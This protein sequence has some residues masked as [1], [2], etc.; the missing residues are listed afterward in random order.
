ML[1]ER[2][3]FNYNVANT[4]TS[5]SQKKN[6]I[7]SAIKTNTFGLREDVTLSKFK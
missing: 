2:K 3:R 4:H 6:Y 7:S 1:T 5:T